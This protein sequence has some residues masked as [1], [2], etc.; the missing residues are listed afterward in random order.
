MNTEVNPSTNTLL[1]FKCLSKVLKIMIVYDKT[2]LYGK[3]VLQETSN[4]FVCDVFKM[5]TVME[6][7]REWSFW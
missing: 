3:I 7:L 2:R 5:A 1:R 4:N 6:L